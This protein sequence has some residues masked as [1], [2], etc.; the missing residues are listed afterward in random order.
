MPV[1][2]TSSPQ[3]TTVN[4]TDM[5]GFVCKAEGLPVPS[6]TWFYGPNQT[7]LSG[8]AHNDLSLNISNTIEQLLGAIRVTSLLAFSSI[9][10]SDTHQYTCVASNVPK[11]NLMVNKSASFGVLVQSKCF[12]ECNI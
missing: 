2:I 10:E 7:D 11:D 1:I 3:N 8:R 9:R 12:K 5:I 4:E 6:F